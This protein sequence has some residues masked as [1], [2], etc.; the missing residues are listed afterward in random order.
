MR[1]LRSIGEVYENAP[2][3]EFNIT[4]GAPLA[5]TDPAVPSRSLTERARDALGGLLA[6]AAGDPSA[7][8]DARAA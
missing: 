4:F 5:A 7:A 6:E 2:P 1:P 3:P 8:A